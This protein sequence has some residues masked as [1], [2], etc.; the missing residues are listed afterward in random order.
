MPPSIKSKGV[1]LI[2]R[3][4]DKKIKNLETWNL[5]GMGLQS[6]CVIVEGPMIQEAQL[7]AGHCCIGEIYGP[8]ILCAALKNLNFLMLI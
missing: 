8:R 5:I 6:L 3:T 4:E 1:F 7:C 2:Y